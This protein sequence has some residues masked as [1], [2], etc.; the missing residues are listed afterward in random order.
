MVLEVDV[1]HKLYYAVNSFKIKRTLIQSK[2]NLPKD[3]EISSYMTVHFHRIEH[4]YSSINI[5]YFTYPF[6]L[7]EYSRVKI[8]LISFFDILKRKE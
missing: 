8:N 5:S 1:N 7:I 2:T 4:L 3:I 6:I